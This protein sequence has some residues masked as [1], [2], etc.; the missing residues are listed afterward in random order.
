MLAHLIDHFVFSSR[1]LAP[2]TKQIVFGVCVFI[3]VGTF[4]W[5]KGVAWGIDGPINDHWGLKW[6]SVCLLIPSFLSVQVADASGVCRIGI[7]ITIN[8]RIRVFSSHLSLAL[9]SSLFVASDVRI[10]VFS[11][12]CFVQAGCI[13]SMKFL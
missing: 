7:S 12:S 4:W 9:S 5:F 6:R 1:R 8:Y 3:I 10:Y 13:M 2:R 11:P